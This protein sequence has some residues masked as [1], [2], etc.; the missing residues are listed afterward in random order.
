MEPVYFQANYVVKNIFTELLKITTETV[1]KGKPDPQ[2]LAHLL[3]VQFYCP[4]L[5]LSITEDK[6]VHKCM[7]KSKT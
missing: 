1:V 6:I 2:V 4:Y 7:N 3:F 5:L